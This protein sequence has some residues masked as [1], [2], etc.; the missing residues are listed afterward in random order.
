MTL[1]QSIQGYRLQVLA[2]AERIGNVSAVCR[3]FGISRTVFYE[4]R[5]AFRQ[6]GR[7]ALRPKPAGPTT[8]SA[9]DGCRRRSSIG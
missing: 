3:Q 2:E 6:Y 4:W 7:D 8:G 5:R 9:V 1:E